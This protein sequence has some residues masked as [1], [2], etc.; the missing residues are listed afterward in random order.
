MN[1]KTAIES[2]LA[3]RCKLRLQYAVANALTRHFREAEANLLFCSTYALFSNPVQRP[4]WASAKGATVEL[5]TPPHLT[6]M[7][8]CSMFAC[9]FASKQ[10]AILTAIQPPFLG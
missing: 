5:Y 9:S 3:R 4:Y 6:K 2:I 8:I 10:L 7:M 1:L